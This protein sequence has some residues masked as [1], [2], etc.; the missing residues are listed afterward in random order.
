MLIFL[1]NSLNDSFKKQQ[2]D[3]AKFELYGI[4]ESITEGMK[5]RSRCKQYKEEKNHV[6]S[7]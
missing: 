1:R 6:I 3:L 2:Y 7:L 5:V 4:Y